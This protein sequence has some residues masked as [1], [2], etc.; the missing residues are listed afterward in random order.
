MKQQVLNYLFAD[1]GYT[2]GVAL[3]LSIPGANKAFANRLNRSGESPALCNQLHYELAKLA[4]IPEGVLRNILNSP[5]KAEAHVPVQEA[6]PAQAT[7][8]IAAQVPEEVGN[9]ISLF[10]QYPFLQNQD[11]PPALKQLVAAKVEAYYA[12]K[13][14]HPKL[15]EAQSEE[16]M[17]LAATA[18]I[19]NYIENRA[20]HA[21]LEHYKAH[22]TVLGKHPIFALQNEVNEI[23]SLSTTELIKRRN[24]TVK[25]INSAKANIAK[26]DKPHLDES[27]QQI[28]E[29]GEYLLEV[30]DKAIAA[31][32]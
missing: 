16:E 23:N 31:K 11:C 8:Q 7:K 17:Q 29:R 20:I 6:A 12:Y 19:E 13:A 27:R 21:E 9:I 2:A 3:Y 5:I 26:G 32:G 18:T 14:A 1:R 4:G 10:R 15:F 28:I 24:A 25:S 22:G 30:I